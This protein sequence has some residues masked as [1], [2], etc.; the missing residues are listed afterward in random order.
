MKPLGISMGNGIVDAPNGNAS[1][2]RRRGQPSILLL[3]AAALTACAT[4]EPPEPRIITQ[5]V[6]VPVSIP[7]AEPGDIPPDRPYAD[8]RL[9]P[10]SD[11]AAMMDAMMAGITERDEDLASLRSIV[12]GCGG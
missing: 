7:C 1:T 9:E 6:E 12:E 3:A 5:R 10:T 11:I 4:P 8:E 2:S